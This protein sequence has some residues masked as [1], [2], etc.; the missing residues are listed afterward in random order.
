MIGRARGERRPDIGGTAV[1]KDPV[2][3]REPP[4]PERVVRDRAEPEL[5]EWREGLDDPATHRM[6]AAVA[7]EIPFGGDVKRRAAPHAFHDCSDVAF[8]HG[9]KVL[10]HF[11]PVRLLE[12]RHFH[13]S[14]GAHEVGAA[15][16]VAQQASLKAQ[17][18][19]RFGRQDR[20]EPKIAVRGAQLFGQTDERPR[21]EMVLDRQYAVAGP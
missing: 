15:P 4:A 19:E 5:G 18:L 10:E 20:I 12:F 2:E 21:E 14:A 17:R 13:P 1:S 3:H 16:Q 8:G 9:A 6:H 11:A 7:T